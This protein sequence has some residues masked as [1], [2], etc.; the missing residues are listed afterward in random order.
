MLISELAIWE[1]VHTLFPIPLLRALKLANKRI[2]LIRQL[3]I[4]SKPGFFA[5]KQKTEKIYWIQMGNY[6]NA[7]GQLEKYMWGIKESRNSFFLLM[8]T[9]RF[10]KF[11][12]CIGLPQW[13]NYSWT[14][15]LNLGFGM[16]AKFSTIMF[17]VSLKAE[18]I[19]VEWRAS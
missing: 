2:L 14:L 7:T 11:D 8:T 17:T 19:T 1:L 13:N 18:E 6:R 9:H 5:R 15:R 3:L 16:V 12:W 10:K 4:Q